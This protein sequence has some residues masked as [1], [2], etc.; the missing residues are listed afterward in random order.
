MCARNNENKPATDV[1]R[2]MHYYIFNSFIKF[3]LST[4]PYLDVNH[5]IIAYFPRVSGKNVPPILSALA[6]DQS[7][8]DELFQMNK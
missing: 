4:K 2:N 6:E 7:G 3:S 1:N 5:K 8:N